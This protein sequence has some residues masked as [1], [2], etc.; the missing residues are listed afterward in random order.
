MT[1]F[2]PCTTTPDTARPNPKKHVNFTRGMVLGVDDFVQEFAYSSGR[3]RWMA[4]DLIGYGTV[5]GLNVTVEKDESSQWQIKVT[6]GVAVSPNGQLIHVTP[7]QC[8]N[9][10]K[11]MAADENRKNMIAQLGSPLSDEVTLY[12]VLSYRYCC[13][14]PVPIPGEPC[15]V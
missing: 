2:N 15:R 10:D 4:R 8:A 1:S 14:D 3:D 5:S 6:A 11:W 13:T 9:I 12:A 7:G